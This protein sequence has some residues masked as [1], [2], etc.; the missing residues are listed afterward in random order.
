MQHQ[1]L[2]APRGRPLTADQSVES[3]FSCCVS[4]IIA[5][6]KSGL[7]A[8]PLESAAVLLTNCLP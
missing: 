4:P 8:S 7:H 3:S 2:M 6:Q 1:C 5:L